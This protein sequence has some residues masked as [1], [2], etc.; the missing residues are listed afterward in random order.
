VQP[1][2]SILSFIPTPCRLCFHWHICSFVSKITQRRT[3]RPIFTKFR[4]KVTHGPRK[5]PL[6]FGGNP[7][8]VNVSRVTVWVWLR[9]QWGGGTAI[10]RMGGCVTVTRRLY[11]SNNFPTSAALA[12]ECALL[13]AILVYTGNRTIKRT[14]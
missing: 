12:E 8:H 1:N 2:G 7:D 11:N 3:T 13:S 14:G 6:D 4:G 10:L 5:K 9:L